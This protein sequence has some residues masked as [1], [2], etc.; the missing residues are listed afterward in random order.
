M[1][2][3]LSIS[4]GGIRGIIPC[5]ML[6]ALEQQTGKTVRD[7]FSYVAGTSTGSD[8]CALIQAGV[9]MQQLAAAVGNDRRKVN[10][11]RQS[12]LLLKV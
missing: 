7:C 2:N 8:L 4:G 1:T 6:I 5:C 12:V 3:T 9:P 10:A 11:D